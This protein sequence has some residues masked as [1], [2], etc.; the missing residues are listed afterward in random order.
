[1]KKFWKVFLSVLIGIF[2]IVS[3]SFWFVPVSP[4]IAI[5]FPAEVVQI[6]DVFFGNKN[7]PMGISTFRLRE[8]TGQG[9][10]DIKKFVED[11]K[12][13]LWRVYYQLDKKEITMVPFDQLDTPILQRIIGKQMHINFV[14]V[15]KKVKFEK[16]QIRI[17]FR[18]DVGMSVVMNFVL[19][20]FMAV[21]YLF[22]LAIGEDE[23]KKAY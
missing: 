21:S 19:L 8:S 17:T 13:S 4:P 10:Y 20:F 3:I 1:M 15:V 22:I 16:G 14:S 11:T 5:D 9:Q 23:K 18:R 12:A 2:F 7:D 6:S